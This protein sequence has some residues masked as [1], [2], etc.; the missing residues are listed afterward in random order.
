MAF[1]RFNRFRR[2]SGF[3]R[4]FMGRA[5]YARASTKGHLTRLSRATFFLTSRP[6]PSGATALTASNFAFELVKILD[7]VSD[8]GTD[9]GVAMAALVKSIDVTHIH[10][11]YGF[12]FDTF[13]IDEVADPYFSSRW[14]THICLC[15]D[16]LD[17]AGLPVAAAST[18]WFGVQ[19]PIVSVGA[20]F[21]GAVTEDQVWPQRVLWERYGE[22]QFGLNRVDN[23]PEGTLVQTNPRT[24][25][26]GGGYFQRRIRTRIG[27]QE[28]LYLVH[29]W[30]PFVA[31]QHTV[32]MRF[33]CGG[34]IYYKVNF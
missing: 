29:S 26:R 25:G 13:A 10:F 5:P 7:H 30:A 16:R 9:S 27:D 11:D 22:L 12:D 33:W 20:G 24:R 31:L 18:G 15:V 28:G 1:R 23:V 32:S 6:S 8:A 2:R 19:S 14:A 4:R 3:R 21:P 17:V 34:A